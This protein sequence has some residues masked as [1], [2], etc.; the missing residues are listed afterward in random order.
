MTWPERKRRPIIPGGSYFIT[1]D[2]YGRQSWF[3]RPQFAQIVVDQW[4]H[5]EVAYGF[6]LAAYCVLPDHYHVVLSLGE[7]KSISQILHAVNSY[8]ATLISRQIGRRTRVKVFGDRA[9]DEVIR[10][11]DMY[12]EKVAYVLLNPW[13]LGLVREPLESYPFSNIDEWRAREGDEFLLE[14]FS[15]CRRWHE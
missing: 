12:W 4:R 5:Y 11:E 14:L 9:W 7:S 13:R 2:T 3:A 6:D 15:R 1:G 8:I 10:D